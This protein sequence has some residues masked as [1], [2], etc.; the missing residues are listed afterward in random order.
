[1]RT[2]LRK[3]RGEFRAKITRGAERGTGTFT[4][5]LGDRVNYLNT[6]DWDKV[7]QGQSVFLSRSYQALLRSA[8][9]RSLRHHYGLVY[10]GN[11]AV[12]AMVAHQVELSNGLPALNP[13]LHSG[14]AH[15]GGLDIDSMM[16]RRSRSVKGG[17][18]RVLVCGDFYV[19]GFHGVAAAPGVEMES[20][21]PAITHVLERI[22]R[23]EAFDPELSTV[24][25]KDVDPLPAS[26]AKL[27]QRSQYQRQ[28][29]SSTMV[30]TMPARWSDYD[31][32]VNHLNVRHRMGAYRVARDLARAGM[33]PR[34]IENLAPVGPRIHA[35]Y[36][37]VQ[38][39]EGLGAGTLPPGFL[40]AMT[41]CLGAGRYRC[42][43]LYWGEDL[44]A[45][46]LSI[47]DRNTSVCHSL[48]W[49]RERCAGLPILPA[50]LQA[51][52]EDALL[53][54]C[55]RVDFGRTA[56]KAK[57]QVGAHPQASE[58]W[59]Q[60]AGVQAPVWLQ[61]AVEPLSHTP[62]PDPVLSLGP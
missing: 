49:D 39:Q 43:G 16:L 41:E 44:V 6:A 9:P 59:V 38:R 11:E 52:I 47:R 7:T 13:D 45:F 51:A 29:T 50:L 23:Q 36:Q 54:G 3:L 48:G 61:P 55:Q 2:R 12:A 21:W 10:A 56:L 37:A 62:A 27:L 31:D 58:I 35:L 18:R 32:Y 60:Q 40:P 42:T 19:S 53:M 17:A 57:A 24:F 46:V 34:K 28:S 25:I 22:Q 1:M 26:A 20:L 14:Q 30:L 8:G 5:A 4:Y 15:I 33:S